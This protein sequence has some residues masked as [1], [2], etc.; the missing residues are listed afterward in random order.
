MVSTDLL[1]CF[2]FFLL[3]WGG[4]LFSYVDAV[5]DGSGVVATKIL[6]VIVSI[7]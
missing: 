2:F 7:V 6:R 1:S 5:L 3:V 4:G